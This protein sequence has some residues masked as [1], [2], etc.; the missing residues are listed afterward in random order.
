MNEKTGELE[1]GDVGA[2]AQVNLERGVVVTNPKSAPAD[3]A[4]F[5]GPESF[6]PE[7]YGF[8][9]NNIKENVAKRIAAYQAKQ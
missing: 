9:Y 7:D 1:I 3:A 4:E 6:H 2:D 8:Y 5:L